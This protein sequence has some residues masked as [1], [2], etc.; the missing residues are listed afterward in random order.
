M[1][2]EKT[3]RFRSEILKTY[4]PLKVLE[5]L[6]PIVDRDRLDEL[7]Y[8]TNGPPTAYICFKGSCKSVENPEKITKI[9]SEKID[10][11]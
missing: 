6:D 8:P 1:K 3:R 9:V 10:G 7:G 4:N 11:N 5:T 2:D